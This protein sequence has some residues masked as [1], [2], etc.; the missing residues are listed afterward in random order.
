MG[1]GKTI[2]VGFVVPISSSVCRYLSWRAAGWS[3]IRSNGRSD[4]RNRI[5][6]PTRPRVPGERLWSRKSVIRAGSDEFLVVGDQDADR[7]LR[8]P[9]KGLRDVFRRLA[10]IRAMYPVAHVEHN[11]AIKT[12]DG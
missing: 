11:Q 10:K 12:S 3:A 8:L 9:S 1:A 2:V 5:A 4:E 6:L 7:Q